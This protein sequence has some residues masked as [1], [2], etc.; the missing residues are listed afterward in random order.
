M[1]RYAS[2]FTFLFGTTGNILNTLVFSQR[3]FRSNPCAICF[4]FSSVANLIAILF[5]VTSR[6]LNGWSADLTNTDRFICKFRTFILN[7]A[8]PVAFWLILLAAI[9]RWLLSSANARYRQISTMKNAIRSM[10]IILISSIVLFSHII[11]CYEPNMIDEPLQCY[12]KNITCRLVSAILFAFVTTFF[13][14]LLMLIFGLMT[15]NNLRQSKNRIQPGDISHRRNQESNKGNQRQRFNKINNH[16]LVML[17]GQ[18][19]LLFMLGLPL[20][21]E[22]LYEAITMDRPT[23][24]VQIAID[25]FVY[26]IVL[27]LNFLANGSPFYIYTLAG[28][29]E[30][31]KAFFKLLSAIGQKI[32]D[33]KR[34]FHL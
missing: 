14:V 24:K 10:I 11:Y 19:V 20:G 26:N 31:R 7:V 1:N 8:R 28:G 13:P 17:F 30:F 29:K 5:G 34:M 33:A 6:M 4:L 2:I 18:I 9:D 15:I 25:K 3:S 22:K 12:G 32:Y 16:L 27:L 23:T 21:I